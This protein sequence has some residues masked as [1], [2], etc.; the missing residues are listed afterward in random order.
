MRYDFPLLAALLI[1][2]QAPL[3]AQ[4]TPGA[5]DAAPHPQIAYQGRLLEAGM[6]VTGIRSFTFT[7]LDATGVELW[8]SGVQGIP[9]NNGLYAVVLGGSGMPEIPQNLLAK[10]NLRLRLAVDSVPLAPDTDLVPAFQ[11]RSA[12]DFTGALA[13]DV[14]GTQNTTTVLRLQGIPLDFAT[15]PSPGQALVFNGSAWVAATGTAGPVGPQGPAGPTGMTGPAGPVGPVG[16]AGLQGIPGPAGPQG[17][18]GASGAA[19]SAGLVWRGAFSPTTTYQARDVVAFGGT[20]YVAAAA[21]L[22][23][24]TPPAAGWDLLA[25]KGDP[26]SMGATGPQGAQGPAGPQGDTGPSGA[27]G[28]QG[29]MGA[30]GP[31]GVQGPSGPQGVPGVDGASVLSGTGAPTMATGKSGDFYIDR[32][33][34]TFYGP[35]AGGSWPAGVSLEVNKFGTN[36]SWA[37]QG[38]EGGAERY[39]GEVWLAAGNLSAGTPC[40]GRLLN[41]QQNQA[42]YAILGTRYGGDGMNTFALPDLRKAAP[43]G[44][45]YVISTVGMFP[46]PL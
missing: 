30:T 6:P 31:Q 34:M 40:D 45:T 18:A 36:T 21:D 46:S 3:G 43:N 33:T 23:G 17:P 38:Q 20:A 44:L 11:A 4:Q 37:A 25:A 41:I 35:K 16:P 32:T 28:A 42:L 7:L 10:A 27:T 24:T 9:V 19:G 14:G 22:T 13:G 12:F 2:A 29:P 5:T 8:N 15:L 26:G 1:A 39:L